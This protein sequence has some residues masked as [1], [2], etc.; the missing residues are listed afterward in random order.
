MAY[1]QNQGRERLYFAQ[2]N[3]DYDTHDAN[4][5]FNGM[6][7]DEWKG[8][9]REQWS[10]KNLNARHVVLIF[11]DKDKDENGILKSLHVH[12]VIYF[13]DAIPQSDAIKRTGCSCDKN[14]EEPKEPA[15]AYGYLLHITEK[16]IQDGKFIYSEAELEISTDGSK[17]N[18]HK[19]ISKA[20]EEKRAKKSE[21]E[22]KKEV[23]DN[24]LNGVYPSK[25]DFLER[26]YQ[27]PSISPTY[28]RIRLL[29]GESPAFSKN[30]DHAW[31]E[32]NR[33]VSFN[34]APYAVSNV[35]DC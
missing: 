24:I 29:I 22:L 8:L 7:E 33:C 11:H 28:K 35:G 9:I 12:A 6:T 21:R 13:K 3:Y 2:R 19:A 4:G 31:E 14:C 25:Q 10:V 20:D 16:A 32:W 26:V 30:I 34:R 5:N 23:L 18:Y 17:F 27:E 15:K 1:K